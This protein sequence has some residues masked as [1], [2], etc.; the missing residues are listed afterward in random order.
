MSYST[1]GSGG[2]GGF[3]AFPYRS[4]H[5]QGSDNNSN[6]NSNNTN[7]NNNNNN[8]RRQRS[9]QKSAAQK[10]RERGGPLIHCATFSVSSNLIPLI[11]GKK[12]KTIQELNRRTK[13]LVDVPRKARQGVPG[14][15][16]QSQVQVQVQVQD[17][18]HAQEQNVDNALK[19]KVNV[20]AS[21]VEYLLYGC[22]ELSLI[23]KEDA[24]Y[25][26]HIHDV[27][28]D[29]TG[30]LKYL[31]DGPGVNIAVAVSD[32]DIEQYHPY[33]YDGPFMVDNNDISIYSAVSSDK[34]DVRDAMMKPCVS[35][36]VLW[37]DSSIL[38]EDGVAVLVDNERFI[39]PGIQARV[40]STM[41]RVNGDCK[42]LVSF[43]YG[44]EPEKTIDLYKKL[45]DK[46]G[47]LEKTLNANKDFFLRDET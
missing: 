40:F 29:L 38:D 1:Q 45:F 44:S 25:C 34:R 5:Q 21:C 7:N 12:G 37:V 39:D 22:W 23:I 4:S 10:R 14:V 3:G 43:I 16:E 32:G 27:G 24:E 13:C 2:G 42:S 17:Q 20:R 36:Y 26:L 8:N 46:I 35:A 11:V 30:V 47:T 9:T 6:N 33:D 18:Q 31:Q 41:R 15:D 19:V 28:L